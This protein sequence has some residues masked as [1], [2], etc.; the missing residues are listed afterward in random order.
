MNVLVVVDAALLY[1]NE[2]MLLAVVVLKV[3]I[4]GMTIC[5]ADEDIPVVPLFSNLSVQKPVPDVPTVR[6]VQS[7]VATNGTLVPELADAPITAVNIAVSDVV[8]AVPI[9]NVNVLVL[10]TEDVLLPNNVNLKWVFAIN[11]LAANAG[12]FAITVSVVLIADES[13]VISSCPILLSGPVAKVGLQPN[14]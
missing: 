3:D 10:E 8:P 11:L 7:T 9:L 4:V 12:V 1:V 13:A 2:M 14:C 6:T 5:R